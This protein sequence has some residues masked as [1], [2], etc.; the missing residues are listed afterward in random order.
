MFYYR[1]SLH[2]RILIVASVAR[3]SDF[4][5]WSLLNLKCM[6]YE[7]HIPFCEITQLVQMLK[8]CMR[9]KQGTLISLLVYFLGKKVE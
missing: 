3:A 5:V 8:D 4:T 7:I 9:R 1:P 2:E 6:A